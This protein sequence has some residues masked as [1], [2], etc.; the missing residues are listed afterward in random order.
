[1]LSFTFESQNS[2]G[3]SLLWFNDHNLCDEDISED[4]YY[5]LF[6][7]CRTDLKLLKSFKGMKLESSTVNAPNCTLFQIYVKSFIVYRSINLD[8]SK[9]FTRWMWKKKMC[10]Y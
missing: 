4:L 10:L 2:Y 6:L 3:S 7:I 9:D 1:M 8:S 5:K